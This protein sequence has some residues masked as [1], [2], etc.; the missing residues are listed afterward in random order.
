MLTSCLWELGHDYEHER[1]S[2]VK[3]NWGTLWSLQ[4]FPESKLISDFKI[5]SFSF[6]F[7][8]SLF[9]SFT[10]GWAVRAGK[11]KGILGRKSGNTVFSTVF[12]VLIIIIIIVLSVQFLEKS[13]AR[14]VMCGWFWARSGVQGFGDIAARPCGFFCISTFSKSSW[15]NFRL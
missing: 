6:F 8:L 13:T 1:E 11:S 2:L 15:N 10:H 14:R 3:V 9:F 4:F 5:E 12:R 7:L